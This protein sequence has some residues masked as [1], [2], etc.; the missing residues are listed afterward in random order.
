MKSSKHFKTIFFDTVKRFIPLSIAYW[1][2]LAFFFPGIEALYELSTMLNNI[3]SLYILKFPSGFLGPMSQFEVCIVCGFFGIVFSA[4]IA[5][6]AFSYLHN[7]R[8]MDFVGSLPVSRRT[9]FLARLTAVMALAIVPVIV[10]TFTGSAVVGFAGFPRTMELMLRICAVIAGNISLVCVLSICSGTVANTVISYVLISFIYPMFMLLVGIYPT[11]FVP[12]VNEFLMNANSVTLLSPISAVFTGT[13]STIS[14]DGMDNF[15]FGFD[16]GTVFFYIWWVV[17][18]VV[19]IGISAILIKKR[20]TERAQ[21]SYAFVAP[22]VVIRFF[23][24]ICVGFLGGLLLGEIFSVVPDSNVDSKNITFIAVFLIGFIIFTFITHLIMHLIYH[25]GMGKFAKW[26]ILFGVEAVVGLS[27]FFTISTDA[28]GYVT[29]VPSVNDVKSVEFSFNDHEFII[30]GV[31]YN[32]LKT[33]D[34]AVI[35]KILNFHK[36]VVNDI[37]EKHGGMYLPVR[38][39]Y[40]PMVDY[41]DEDFEYTDVYDDYRN[42]IRLVMPNGYTIKFNLKDGSSVKRYY[43]SSIQSIV[44][45]YYSDLYK[46]FKTANVNEIGKIPQEYAEDLEVFINMD[47]IGYDND[48][49]Y[50]DNENKIRGLM[51]AIK[52]DYRKV[53]YI[54][55]FSRGN[56]CCIVV[57]YENEYSDEYS[58]SQ[59]VI[60]FDSRYVNTIKYLKEKMF[61]KNPPQD[62]SEYME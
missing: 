50:T 22:Y 5:F 39:I 51:K 28:I 62:Y 30:D 49:S 47:S 36:G 18:T 43:D 57:N 16:A 31:D 27:I 48:Y 21:N 40:P 12:G 9:H 11:A 17:F 59:E 44:E 1:G 26:L 2:L 52:K 60:E 13:F 56:Y 33:E 32:K 8:Q 25:K 20:K 35:E 23:T 46:I 6:I 15:S 37:K 61:V 24:S 10:V 29:Y 4:I 58:F 55:D 53:G 45:K 38:Y 14:N 41:Y 34:K 3:G 7:K 19:L 42:N 54:S